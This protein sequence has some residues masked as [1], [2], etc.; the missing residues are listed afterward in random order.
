M[1]TRFRCSRLVAVAATWCLL[2]ISWSYPAAAGNA[3]ATFVPGPNLNQGRN[4][5]VLTTLPD[6]RVGVFGGHKIINN[7][8]VSLNNFEIWNP[9][10][11]QFTLLNMPTHNNAALARLQDGRY[12]LAG[13]DDFPN[14]LK[15]A[16]L[17]NPNGNSINAAGL[18]HITHAYCSAAP[19]T[20]GRVL[21]VG[22]AEN[23]P[24]NG[25]DL[26]NPLTSGFT[27][28][29]VPTPVLTYPVVLPTLDNQAAILGGSISGI[30]R[31]QVDLYN[32]ATN[33]TST[34]IPTLFP[35]RNFIAFVP[36]RDCLD[37]HRLPDGR[38]L[39]A[40]RQSTEFL[41]T[42]DPATK[43]FANYLDL[44]AGINPMGH[45][46]VDSARGKAYIIAQVGFSSPIKL[47]I[48][49]VELASQKVNSPDGFYQLP[50]DFSWLGT[51]A[52]LSD[53]RLLLVGGEENFSNP[54]TRVASAKT[55]FAQVNAVNQGSLQLMLL[56]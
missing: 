1:K 39:L 28:A 4:G 36:L 14:D 23:E 19:L 18:M 21:V 7:A 35:E 50:D 11:N 51:T 33:S 46:L 40:A 3:G 44:P 48:Y 13:S 30:P 26:F 27:S 29:A 37:S 2:L 55:W 10:T 25:G 42:F 24:V 45:P 17:F 43:Q 38:Y 56:D 16:D 53:G 9:Q 5:H 49:T 54:A 22:S 52:L 34:L 12:L 8:V 47:R 31:R 15:T 20:D 6:G 32:P 41:F